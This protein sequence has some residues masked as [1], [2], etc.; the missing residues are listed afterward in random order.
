[1]K[2]FSISEALQFGWHK[3]REHS[4]I[5]FQV[6]LTLFALQVVQEMVSA[7]IGRTLIGALASAALGILSIVISVGFTI[8]AI[9]LAHGHEAHYRD[10]FPWNR[11][12]W[13]YFLASALAGLAVV[14]GLIL[15]VIPGIIVAL[16]LSMVRFAIVEGARP[17]ESL[18]QS[19]EATRGH[20]WRLL[21]LFL[22]LVGINIVGAILL[23]V[24]LLVTVPLSMLAWA[25]VYLKLK[26][27][28]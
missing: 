15:L 13:L 8:I 24:G 4:G 5:L 23:L 21:G 22:V 25:H 14:G 28:S 26:H 6:M 19:W 7:S 20:F 18:H 16:R 3:T 27:R 17:F 10:L 11:M 1:M 2:T 12:V 9:K